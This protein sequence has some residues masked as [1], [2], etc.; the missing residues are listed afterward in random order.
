MRE[1][2]SL[3]RTL[4]RF[5]EP[6][7]VGVPL[8]STYLRAF[9]HPEVRLW[10]PPETFSLWRRLFSNEEGRLRVLVDVLPKYAQKKEVGGLPL[11]AEPFAAVDA[12]LGFKRVK[13]LNVLALADWVAHHSTS[14]DAARDFAGAHG[15]DQEFMYLQD[16]RRR[17]GVKVVEPEELR[18]AHR[19]AT[20]MGKFPEGT[21]FDELLVREASGL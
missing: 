9:L 6:F 4:H 1:L 19:R 21:R 18:E 2:L 15:V 8:T 10:V 5:G 11:L 13:N 7:A 3:L 12:L 14:L 16:H 20:E 17:R